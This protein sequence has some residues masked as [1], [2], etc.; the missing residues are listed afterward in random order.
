MTVQLD[1]DLGM[2]PFVPITAADERA[3]AAKLAAREL[4]G[5]RYEHRVL[6]AYV[7]GQHPNWDSVRI[8]DALNIDHD[9]KVPRYLIDAFLESIR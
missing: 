2:A 8:G 3:L 4:P 5:L 9:V 1:N 6:V 7:S